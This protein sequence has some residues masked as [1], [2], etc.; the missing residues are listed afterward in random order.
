MMHN[1]TLKYIGMA[2]EAIMYTIMYTHVF[3]FALKL[4]QMLTDENSRHTIFGSV[5]LQGQNTKENLRIRN[6]C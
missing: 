4:D 2:W 1:F 5:K 6:F 3:C